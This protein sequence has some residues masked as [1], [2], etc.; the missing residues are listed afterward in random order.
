MAF[1]EILLFPY[2]VDFV[3]TT[4]QTFNN[5]SIKWHPQLIIGHSLYSLPIKFNPH[6]Y[7]P[8]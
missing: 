3:A 1:I 6:D 5:Y 4:I 7:A 8:M 2:F